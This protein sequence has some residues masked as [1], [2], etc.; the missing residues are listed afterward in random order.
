MT[1][2]GNSRKR[3]RG[4]LKTDTKAKGLGESSIQTMR[5]TSVQVLH[6]HE[7]QHPLHKEPQLKQTHFPH[8]NSSFCGFI[9]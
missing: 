3:D 2:Q 7:T 5:T 9:T 6:Y 4:Q 8:S 1:P